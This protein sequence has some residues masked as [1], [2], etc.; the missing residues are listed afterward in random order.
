M[1]N[2]LRY[3]ADILKT[4]YNQPD[5]ALFQYIDCGGLVKTIPVNEE[6]ETYKQFTD[7]YPAS[8]WVPPNVKGTLYK[9]LP[10]NMG[11]ELET[12]VNHNLFMTLNQYPLAGSFYTSKHWDDTKLDCCRG[13]GGANEITCGRYWRSTSEKET[14]A[15]DEIMHQFCLANP[16][17]KACSCTTIINN[18]TNDP[19]IAHLNQSPLCK[20]DCM[21][22][23]YKP[24]T[25]RGKSCPP[26]TICKQEMNLTA[27]NSIYAKDVAQIM[28]CPGGV[29]EKESSATQ[30]T[31]Q[32]EINPAIV[33]SSQQSQLDKD[34]G[35]PNTILYILIS[36]ISVILFV[37]GG[38]A[39]YKNRS[40]S[41]G[42]S[43]KKTS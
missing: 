10:R 33:L 37:I 42:V 8:M 24:V 7:F 39:I 17:D 34:N 14:G 32:N 31:P 36:L 9:L 43:N 2:C 38:M 1:N 19:Y 11:V 35:I 26:I 30:L 15:C 28:Q 20:S 23:G 16:N 22:Y 12:S 6:G 25:M 41:L 4:T 29:I 21:A 40:S 5:I 27:G 3:Q 13:T 18:P